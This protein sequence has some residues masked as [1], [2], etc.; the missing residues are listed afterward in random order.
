[1]NISPLRFFENQGIKARERQVEI[2]NRVEAE[3]DKYK[4]FLISAP[5]GVGKTYIATAIASVSRNAYLLTSTLQLQ[6]QYEGSWKTLVNLKGKGNYTCALNREFTVDA[7][8]CAATYELVRDCVRNG[9]CDYYKQKNK[10]MNAQS[11]I[12]NPVYFLYSTHCGFGSEEELE[13]NP[14]K[15]RNVLIVDEA[16]NLEKHLCSFAECK[17]DPNQLLADHGV[18]AL[19]KI[20]FNGTLGHD[21]QQLQDLHTLLNQRAGELQEQMDTEFPKPNPG[22]ER[23]WAKGISK[24]VAEKVKKLN[25]RIYALDKLIQPLN[26]FFGTHDTLEELEERWLMSANLEENTIQ[27]SPLRGGFLFH[28]YMGRM[29]EKFVLMSATL[30]D[31]ASMCRELG[32]DPDEALFIETGTPFSPAKS[33]IISMPRLEMGRGRIE[34]SFEGMAKLVTDILEGHQGERGIIHS[35]TYRIQDELAKRVPRKVRER[36]LFRDMEQHSPNAPRYPRKVP[37]GELL[38]Q[39]AARTDSI[40]LSPSMMEG[41]DLY[42]DLSGFQIILK[43]PWPSLGDPRIKAKADLDSDWYTNSVW[44]HLMQASGRSTRNEE[45]SSVTY[46]LDKSYPYFYNKWKHRLPEWFTAR[47][48]FED[49]GATRI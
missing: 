20:E 26:I 23:S 24:H 49:N 15:K 28:E 18:R 1:M 45:D 10:A 16:H 44:L 6:E 14:W 43:M 11:M 29:A 8:P 17:I 35:A 42:D 13:E 40:L 22:S 33:P 48:V 34:Q 38:K 2:L 25:T 41:V 46:V 5:T 9:I 36:F 21:Y 37:N 31:K 32:I 47:H 7:A 4:Y 30:G 19:K 3:W 39:H 27:L 12:T